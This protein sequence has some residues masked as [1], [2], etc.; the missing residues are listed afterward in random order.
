[1]TNIINYT[2]ARVS[3]IGPSTILLSLLQNGETVRMSRAFMQK[4]EGLEQVA[5]GD[6]LSVVLKNTGMCAPD[7]RI[8][9]YLG[10]VPERVATR[11]DQNNEFKASFVNKVI[12]RTIAAANNAR[13]WR[14]Q[15][16]KRYR[17]RLR[18]DW[19]G[20]V[21]STLTSP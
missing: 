1:M 19:G 14:Y 6:E 16:P 18:P 2:K 3:S 7:Q 10:D 20:L 12:G 11:E 9:K 8:Y 17:Q 15:W 4:H 5:L 13:Q 21:E